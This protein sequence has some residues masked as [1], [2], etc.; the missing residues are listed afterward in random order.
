MGEDMSQKTLATP[1]GQGFLNTHH[2]FQGGLCIFQAQT[3]KNSK[4]FVQ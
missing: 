4:G 2:I 3:N 1:D